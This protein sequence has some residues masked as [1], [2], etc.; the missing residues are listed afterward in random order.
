MSSRPSPNP[1]PL[2]LPDT[3]TPDSL[4]VLTELASILERIRPPQS[5]VS[6]SGAGAGVTGTTPLPSSS[7]APDGQVSLKDLPAAT[8]PL[9][10]KIQ[11]ARAQIKALP[12][13]ERTIP[14]QEEEISELKAKLEEQKQ[15]LERLR[16]RGKEFVEM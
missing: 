3:L 15:V 10:H 13:M 6:L 9:K 2:A 8:D 14:E 11:K 7:A 16:Q 4:D 1:H 12:D 5:T